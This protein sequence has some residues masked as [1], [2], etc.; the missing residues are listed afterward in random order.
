MSAT[1]ARHGRKVG[2][3][4]IVG[5]I[6][7]AAL[8]GSAALTYGIGA[9]DSAPSLGSPAYGAVDSPAVVKA[10]TG[11]VARFA[12]FLD[13]AT[14]KVVYIS[15]AVTV[16]LAR[17]SNSG[18]LCRVA[19]L[20]SGAAGVGCFEETNPKG[21]VS[22]TSSGD[23]FGDAVLVVV[24]PDGVTD[25]SLANGKS[26]PVENNVAVFEGTDTLPDSVT[27]KTATNSLTIGIVAN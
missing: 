25:V 18:E 13:P 17:G 4:G 14:A 8:A 12:T 3:R 1:R 16:Y 9:L 7:M 19:V 15:P 6:S 23:G 21:S 10:S 20:P 22:V 11:A 2:R 27:F 26:G 24:A 5:I